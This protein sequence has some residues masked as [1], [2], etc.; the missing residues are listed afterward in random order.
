MAVRDSRTGKAGGANGGTV[1][2]AVR[3]A[4][5]ICAAQNVLTPTLTPITVKLADSGISER[6]A[7]TQFRTPIGTA[8]YMRHEQVRPIAPRERIHDRGGRWGS[9]LTGSTLF[10]HV[11]A[12]GLSSLFPT[13]A[14]GRATTAASSSH[15]SCCAPESAVQFIRAGSEILPHRRSCRGSS[16]SRV[17]H[18]ILGFHVGTHYIAHAGL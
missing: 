5:R 11:P 2:G 13:A 10:L 1:R 8:Q 6:T 12:D 15:C 17:R 9:S 16:F 7:R 18:L 14:T 3:A 4:R